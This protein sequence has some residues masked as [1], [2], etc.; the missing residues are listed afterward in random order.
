MAQGSFAPIAG[1]SEG[2]ISKG[3]GRRQSPRGNRGLRPSPRIAALTV[4]DRHVF[5][6]AVNVA[7]WG[8]QR[9]LLSA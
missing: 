2:H 9:L 7:N 3:A 4:D 1:L 8:P 6:S 5:L